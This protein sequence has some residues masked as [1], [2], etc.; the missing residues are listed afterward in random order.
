[1]TATSFLSPPGAVE[2][3]PGWMAMAADRLDMTAD[4]MRVPLPTWTV[5]VVAPS[6]QWAAVRTAVDVIK[7]PPGATRR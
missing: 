2:L 3:H 5:T 6:T 7:V 1:M 4:P